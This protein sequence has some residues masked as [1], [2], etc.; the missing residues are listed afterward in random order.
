M[1]NYTYS[2]MIIKYNYMYTYKN[3]KYKYYY[4][5]LYFYFLLIKGLTKVYTIRDIKQINDSPH[6]IVN[7][8]AGIIISILQSFVSVVLSY[9]VI[10]SRSVTFIIFIYKV[11]NTYNCKY[12]PVFI[13]I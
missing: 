4:N 2:Y 5:C 13:L 10:L 9:S 11:I 7:N 3:K 12:T 8:N 1:N 6:G